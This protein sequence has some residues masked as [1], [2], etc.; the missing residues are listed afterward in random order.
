MEEQNIIAIRKEDVTAA[1]AAFAELMSR[2]EATMNRRAKEQI[3]EYKNLSAGEL[4]HVSRDTVKESCCGTPFNP[5]NVILVSGQKFPD[6]LADKYY[7]VE[8]K[9]TS[10]NHWTSTGSSIVETTRDK[11]V[12]HIYM[13]FGKL[14]GAVAEFRCRPY[15][16]VLSEIAVTH[17]PRYL[18][19]M[20]LEE[21]NTIFDKMNI[22]YD[23]FRKSS[24]SISKVKEYYK[25][26][27]LE[28]GNQ[29]PWWISK[30]EK[31]EVSVSM[32]I[33]LW[34][35]LPT[36]E[37]AELV[38]QMIILFPEV[39]SSDYNNAALWLAAA[40]GIVCKNIRDPF[41]AGG[42]VVSI[43]GEA[44]A[45]PLPR[46]IKTLSGRFSQI[47]HYLNNSDEMIDHIV[48]QNPHLL[49]GDPYE[50]WF[51]EIEAELAAMNIAI[52]IREIL[53]SGKAI[54]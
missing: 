36:E 5:E 45:K 46:I 25:R 39:I 48:E 2:T 26:K 18:I 30:D 7:G 53:E 40:K 34:G 28:N 19:D 20:T 54:V 38:S 3:Q 21:G 44:L 43:D 6:I 27:A 22:P 37:K 52:P 8:V 24:D 14:G 29:M 4:E 15:Q 35:G 41:S 23:S 47:R 42:Q 12:E 32:N 11:D 50:I 33:R 31:E 49:T 17:S 51:R 13:L 9:S 16:D 1:D 10:K